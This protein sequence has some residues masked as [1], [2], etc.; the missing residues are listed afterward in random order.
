MKGIHSSVAGR[1]NVLIFPDLN[2]GNIASSM[3]QVVSTVNCYGRVLTG[4]TK[5]VAEISRGASVNEIFGTSVIVGA[6][7]VDRRFLSTESL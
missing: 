7:A 1:A 5:P 4:L 2:S 3:L 6:Q